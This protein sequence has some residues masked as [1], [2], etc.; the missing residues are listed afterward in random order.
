[1]RRQVDWVPSL[2]VALLKGKKVRHRVADR[3]S[4]PV[5]FGTGCAL[6]INGDDVDLKTGCVGGHQLIAIGSSDCLAYSIR[7]LFAYGII[8]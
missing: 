4:S 1:L 7:K 6:R 3:R 5:A 8:P 2:R